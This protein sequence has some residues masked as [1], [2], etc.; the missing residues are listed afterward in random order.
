M[1]QKYN[2]RN[3]RSK[4]HLIPYI[5]NKSRFSDIFDDLVPDDASANRIVDV[6][7][8]SGAFATYCCFRF[9]S[10]NVVYNDNNPVLCNFIMAVRDDVDNLIIQYEKHRVKSSPEYYTK[11]RTE[12]LTDGTAEAGR[13]MYLAKNAFSGKIRFNGKNKFNTPMRK[14]TKCPS[15]Q[16]EKIRAI[17]HA[18][19]HME[20]K[21]KDF[22]EFSDIRQ[23]FLYL[24]PP[25]MNNANGHYNGVIDTESFARFVRATT[26]HNRIMI[27]EQN[28]P[29]S[30]GVP[31][32]YTIH[33]VSL[34]R[35][36]QYITQK[37]SEE[38]I[39]INYKV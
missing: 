10:S 17:S 19:R 7:G 28:E 24:D 22:E 33:R 32:S 3:G 30:I 9:G 1:Q 26:K 13:F 25:Y 8:G 21:N 39:A 31:S 23:A 34:R 12:S 37:N 16:R 5:G 18:I 11:M 6:F 15:I 27:S 29:D 4:Y 2:V 14:G 35:S 36:L 38:I 20:I